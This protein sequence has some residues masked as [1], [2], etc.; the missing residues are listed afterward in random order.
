MIQDLSF[1][2]LLKIVDEAT[3]EAAIVDP[4]A[5]EIVAAAAK[6]ENVNLTTVLT[7]HH[8]W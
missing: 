6:E 3:N 7:T 2:I 1:N 4:V 5:P 8:H